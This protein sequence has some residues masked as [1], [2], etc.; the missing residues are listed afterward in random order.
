MALEPRE[1]YRLDGEAHIHGPDG[2]LF[3]IC[4]Q[5]D[6]FP[7]ILK[8]VEARYARAQSGAAIPASVL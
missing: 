3:P 6:R 1:F 7:D 4:H 5:Y 2:R 8:A